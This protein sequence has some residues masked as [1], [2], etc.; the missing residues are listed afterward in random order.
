MEDPDIQIIQDIESEEEEIN[1]LLSWKGDSNN[2]ICVEK[3]TFDLALQEALFA[4]ISHK[5]QAIILSD[6][7]EERGKGDPHNPILVENYVVGET[8]APFRKTPSKVSSFKQQHSIHET[9]QSS[10]SKP[11][12]EMIFCQIC[13]ETRHPNETF[14]IKQCSHVFCTDCIRGHVAAKIQENQTTVRCPDLQCDEVL[15]LEFCRPILPLEVF[16]RW[17]SVLCESLILGSMK[18]YCPFKDCSA[19]LVDE[20]ESDST[21]ITMS[22]CPHCWRLFCAQCKV[23]WHSDVSC[24]E[25]QKLKESERGQEDLMLMKL[26]KEKKWQRCPQCGFYVERTDGCIFMKCR[27][28][29]CFCY[30]CGGP[31]TETSHYCATCKR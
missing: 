9:E 27:C 22:E 30:H 14:K 13:M 10:N 17:G 7:Q 24:E 18:F 1:T 25:F 20:R 31:M 6:T 12:Q 29:Y 19:L 23:P 5:N 15:E 26:A 16:E 2:P 8:L 28:R 3:Y 21:V 11:E 4:S